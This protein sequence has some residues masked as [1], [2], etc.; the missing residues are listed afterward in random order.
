MT[1]KQIQHLLGYLGYYTGQADGI[2]GAQTA[3]AI[4]AFQKAFGGL[5]VDGIAGEKTQQALRKAVWE[6]MPQQPGEDSGDSSFWNR[7]RYFRR[8]EFRCQCG[9]RYCRGFP[10]EPKEA[11]VLAGEQIREH[12]G[13]PVAVSSGVRCPRHNADVGGMINSKH[14]SG[15]A[16]DF[17]PAGVNAQTVL[18]YVRQL[19]QI[20]YAYAI[21][22]NYVHIELR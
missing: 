3:A 6:G 5:D 15:K 4:R 8:E 14:L 11:L 20:S 2:A 9:G 1:V 16:M 21:D 18:S 17:S 10:A 22:E 7:V 12:F 19:S 13:V